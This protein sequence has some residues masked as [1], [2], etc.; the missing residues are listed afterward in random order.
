MYSLKRKQL[1]I[2][3]KMN[4]LSENIDLVDGLKG[5]P[6]SFAAEDHSIVTHSTISDDDFKHIHNDNKL[7]KDRHLRLPENII[8][9]N[10]KHLLKNVVSSSLLKSN[11]S[12]LYVKPKKLS[13]DYSFIFAKNTSNIASKNTIKRDSQNMNSTAMYA[14]ILA[15][16]LKKLEQSM[17]RSESSRSAILIHKQKISSSLSHCRPNIDDSSLGKRK[18]LMFVH[19]LE[20]SRKRFCKYRV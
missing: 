4:T 18:S 10:S 13:N 2:K 1:C 11:E 20:E 9:S 8:S 14:K 15:D 5:I 12:D 7:D 19:E 3:G 6:K 16:S 17:R